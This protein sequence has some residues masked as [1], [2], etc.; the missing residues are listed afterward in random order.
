VE[1][2]WRIEWESAID[3]ANDS[4]LRGEGDATEGVVAE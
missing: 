4:C 3:E 2:L 1:A